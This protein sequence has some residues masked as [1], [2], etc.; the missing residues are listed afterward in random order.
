[1]RYYASYTLC[2]RYLA[3]WPSLNNRIDFYLLPAPGSV[4]VGVPYNYFIAVFCSVQMQIKSIRKDLLLE[5][6]M[7]NI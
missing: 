7:W 3:P 4:E 1:M 6:D 2:P 5:R